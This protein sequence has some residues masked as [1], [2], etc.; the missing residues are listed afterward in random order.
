MAVWRGSTT[1]AGGHTLDSIHDLPRFR[2]CE[3][4][5]RMPDLADFGL[6]QILQ[7]ASDADTDAITDYC[8]E[9]GL[10]REVIPQTGMAAY[11]YLIDIDG[12]ANAWGLFNKLLIGSTV[13]KVKSSG[14]RQ[15]YYDDLIEWVH[16]VPVHN[17]LADLKTKL[18]WCRDNDAEARRIAQAGRRLADSMTFETEMARFAD[19]L[20]RH[21]D[22][23]E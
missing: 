9:R 4:G 10:M 12:N 7:T 1:G 17:D 19:S 6:V 21:M 2:L 5:A 11:K 16:Y 15:W 8:R 14:Y 13:L 22:V 20:L 3:L 18:R 23:V